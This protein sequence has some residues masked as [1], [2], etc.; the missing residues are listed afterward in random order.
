M[1]FGQLRRREF[2]SLIGGPLMRRRRARSL[3]AHC[4]GAVVRRMM[5]HNITTQE[6]IL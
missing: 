6:D 2:I 3:A 4:N 5:A 1:Q